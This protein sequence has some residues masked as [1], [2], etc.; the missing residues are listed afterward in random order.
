MKYTVFPVTFAALVSLTACNTK[1]YPM[2]SPEPEAS[3][4]MLSCDQLQVEVLRVEE[5]RHQILTTAKWDWRSFAGF[6]GNLGIGNAMAK[7]EAELA[8]SERLHTLRRAQ[9]RG[10]C[11]NS[12]PTVDELPD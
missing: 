12:R 2:A 5:A 3:S 4:A 6:V 9:A 8:L 1:Y 10:G 11:L 7:S